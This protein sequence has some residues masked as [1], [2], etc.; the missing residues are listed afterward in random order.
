MMCIVLNRFG[1]LGLPAVSINAAREY[2]NKEYY[3]CLK[4]W[5]STITL[6]FGWS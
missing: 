2:F 4:F 3:K 6:H 5:L 1:L